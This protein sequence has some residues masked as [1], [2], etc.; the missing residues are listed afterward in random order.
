MPYNP[1]NVVRKAPPA[2]VRTSQAAALASVRTS[3]AAA[4]VSVH[5]SCV[6]A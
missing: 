4:L 5:S 3:H 1:L 6:L 2:S